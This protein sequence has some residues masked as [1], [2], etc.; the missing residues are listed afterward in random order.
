M[1]DASQKSDSRQAPRRSLDKVLLRRT[2]TL[3]LALGILAALVTVFRDLQREKEALVEGVLNVLLSAVPSAAAAAYDYD[4]QAAEQVVEG[5]FL[6]SAVTRVTIVNGGFEMVDSVR[7]VAP[8]LPRFTLLGSPD[9]VAFERTLYEP[10][11]I[12]TDR[13][14]GKLLITVD[15]SLVAPEVIERIVSFILVTTVKNVAFGILLYWFVFNVLARQISILNRQLE[16]WRPGDGVLQVPTLAPILRRTEFEG[17]YHRSSE[18]TALSNT[19]LNNV[20]KSRDNAIVDNAA[21]AKAVSDRTLMLEEANQR[22]QQLAD[23]VGLTGIKNRAAFDRHLAEVFDAAKAT[24]G[25]LEVLLIDIDLFKSY[26]DFYGHQAGDDALERVAKLLAHIAEQTKS[27]AARYGGEEF[28]LVTNTAVTG[29]EVAERVHADLK[30]ADIE[31]QQSPVAR[32]VTASVGTASI[33]DF[34]AFEGPDEILS[35]ADD[36]LYEAKL[37]GRNR[38]VRSTADI[39]AMA[40]ERR[41]SAQVLFTAIERGEFEPFLQH[42]VDMRS[43]EIVGAE[44]LAR[45]VH[46]DGT[47]LP[48]SNFLGI[49]EKAGVTQKIDNIMFEKIAAFL[50]AYPDALP[51]LSINMTGETLRNVGAVRRM[52]E[53]A[54]TSKTVIVVELLETA[55]MDQPDDFVLWNLETLRDAGIEIHIDDFGTGRSSIMTLMTIKPDRLKIARELVALLGQQQGQR[56]L[57]KSIVEIARSLDMEVIAEG[58]ETSEA[59]QILL[60]I[61][62]PIQQGYLYSKPVSL[63]DFICN[64]NDARISFGS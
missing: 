12:G 13:R 42:Q 21:L 50:A 59:A 28:V 17:L 7:D 11:S 15:R 49:A 32:H 38:T 57:C 55:F 22:L 27:F 20:K 29:E 39:R 34:E 4:Q 40:K 3:A 44:A 24:N 52:A 54:S 26:N 5:L 48:P 60:A 58:V 61:G 16:Q 62:C 47:I 46:G 56:S 31:H 35:A 37:S 23:H 53:L 6:Q 8:T 45:W 64:A 10:E 14:I 19:A 25:P 9:V 51:K 36:A 33:G 43:G 41:L 1:S 30:A 63:T 2:L 18:L